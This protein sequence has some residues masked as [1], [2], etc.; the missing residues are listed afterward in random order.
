MAEM[1]IAMLAPY[2]DALRK[3]AS[4]FFFDDVI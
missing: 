3:K 4:V 1:R 2:F